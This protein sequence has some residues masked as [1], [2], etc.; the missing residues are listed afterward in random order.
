MKTLTIAIIVGIIS[1]QI[2]AGKYVKGKKL[3]IKFWTKSCDVFLVF[4]VAL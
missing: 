3:K 2:V 1:V 4:K